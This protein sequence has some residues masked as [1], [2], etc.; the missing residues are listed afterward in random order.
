MEDEIK[1]IRKALGSFFLNRPSVKVR[2]VSRPCFTKNHFEP[3]CVAAGKELTLL[4][5][6][7]EGDCLCIFESPNKGPYIIDVDHRDIAKG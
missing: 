4:E 7:K 3:L 2:M 6:N 1:R 5:R